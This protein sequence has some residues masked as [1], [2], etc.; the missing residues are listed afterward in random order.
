MDISSISTGATGIL[1]NIPKAIAAIRNLLSGVLPDSYLM[2][3]IAV[4]SFIIA[5]YWVKQFVSSGLLKLSILINIVLLALLI[6]TVLVY[7]G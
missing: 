5:F 1:D 4:I 2:L 6:F 3:A 7:V